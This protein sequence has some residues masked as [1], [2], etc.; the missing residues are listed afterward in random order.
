[1]FDTYSSEYRCLLPQTVDRYIKEQCSNMNYGKTDMSEVVKA[2]LIMSFLKE[3]DYFVSCRESGKDI[4]QS[5]Q[6]VDR[7][8]AFFDNEAVGIERS[9]YPSHDGWNELLRDYEDCILVYA[10]NSSDIILHKGRL[11]GI[12][13]PIVLLSLDEMSDSAY[14]PD[15]VVAIKL[16]NTAIS[17]MENTFIRRNFPLVYNRANSIS[18]LLSILKPNK[19]INLTSG[20]ITG[21]ILDR[22][23]H[24]TKRDWQTN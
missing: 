2:L 22:L 3:E 10:D 16:E 8:I 20:T 18:W 17:K 13:T 12:T 7:C 14:F 19:I 5:M 21:M 24:E 4:S 23:Y 6:R 11:D 9:V 1:M 15:N